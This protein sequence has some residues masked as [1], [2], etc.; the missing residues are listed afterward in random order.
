MATFNATKKP[1]NS[2]TVNHESTP[3]FQ[4]NDKLH[5][6]TAVGACFV[7]EPK[8]Y[9]DTTP[10][11]VLVARRVAETDPTFIAKLAVYARREL[12]MRSVSQLLV[13]VLADTEAAKG[14]GLVRA[15]ARGIIRRGDDAPAL[16][17]AWRALHPD[18]VVPNGMRRG[19]ADALEQMTPY[20]I[21]KYQLRGHSVTMRDA[22]RIARPVTGDPELARAF[23]RCV[24]RTLPVPESYNDV[25]MTGNTKDAWLQLMADKNLPYMA[26]L[27]NLRAML[28]AGVPEREL[29]ARIADADAVHKS[30]VMPFR[31][32]SAYKSCAAHAS[33]AL[34]HAMN[35]A[36][37]TSATNLPR[38]T[39]RTA[40]LIDTS[41][42]MQDPVSRRSVV[43]CTDAAAVL[44][45]IVCSMADAAYPFAFAIEVTSINYLDS[46]LGFI[47]TLQDTFNVWGTDIE[48]AVEEIVGRRL[49]VDR[50]IILTDN[51][52]NDQIGVAQ[53]ALDRLRET[54]GHDVWLHAWDLQGYGT[55]QFAGEHVTHLAGF[56][57]AAL[58]FIAAAEDGFA[59]QLDAIERTRLPERGEHIKADLSFDA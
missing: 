13:C 32:Y 59:T 52:A 47:E 21:A 31:I 14:T 1:E 30:G 51:E 15:A 43:H 42:S 8:F 44:G 4:L 58:K 40:V 28:D 23:A 57:D 55:T 24:A 25:R 5:L 16:I 54:L 56:S 17:A 3:A 53:E 22:L 46:P 34:W 7:A 39:G 26:L 6:M 20:D 29:I 36:L 41:A 19:I 2:M 33:S 11:I 9:G 12:M 50:V 37:L 10:E 48:G 49:D 38:L 45:A 18:T 27:R 35:D